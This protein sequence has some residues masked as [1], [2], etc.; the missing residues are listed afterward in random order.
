MKTAFRLLI[1]LLAL[2][3]LS[4]CRF[5]FKK[6]YVEKVHDITIVSLDPDK[7]VLEVSLGVHNPNRYKLKLNQMDISLLTRDRLQIG[8]ATMK[9]PVEIPKKRSNALNFLITLQTRPTI[10]MINNSD[11]KLFFY[12]QGTGSGKVLGSRKNFEFEEPY[13]LDVREQIQ[14]VIGNFSGLAEQDLFKIKRSYLSKVGITESQVRIDFLIM[15]PYG[16]KFRLKAFPSSIKI[17]DKD[18]GSGDLLEAMSFDEKVF[19]REGSMV[20]KLNNWKSLVSAVKGAL[21]GE[22][23]Y[24]VKGKIQL[25]AYGMQFEHPF[26]YKDSIPVNLSELIF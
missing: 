15:N 11:Q 12:I 7:T 19:S 25:E 20:F 16:L 23:A 13:E 17:A 5:L 9:E 10:T 6:P 8:T 4:S 3:S 24:E 18:A 14:K 21:N 2:S 1:I 22:V 26:N